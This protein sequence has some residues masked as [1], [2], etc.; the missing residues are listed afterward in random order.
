MKDGH[1]LQLQFGPVTLMFTFLG[2]FCGWLDLKIG[3]RHDTLRFDLYK[4]WGLLFYFTGNTFCLLDEI[5]Y[6]GFIVTGLG[7]Y[8]FITKDRIKCAKYHA[9]ASNYHFHAFL[10]LVTI[11]SPYPSSVLLAKRINKYILL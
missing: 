2:R 5:C 3:I 10:F 7:V 11:S 6:V 4:W 1:G 9:N 8:T